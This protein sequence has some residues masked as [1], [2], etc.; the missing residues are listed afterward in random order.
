MARYEVT[1][2]IRMRP[3]WFALIIFLALVA[4]GLFQAMFSALAQSNDA[5]PSSGYSWD[6]VPPT[7]TVGVNASVVTLGPPVDGRPASP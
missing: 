7:T 6:G 1:A 4:G 5:E 3:V 2:M